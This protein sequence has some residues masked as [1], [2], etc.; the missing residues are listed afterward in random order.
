MLKA[1][2]LGVRSTRPGV[3]VIFVN[4]WETLKHRLSATLKRKMGKII[5]VDSGENNQTHI[6][7]TGDLSAQKFD[8][9]GGYVVSYSSVT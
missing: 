9:P 7:D 2:A 5:P 6:H 3:C 1:S 4:G 8:D